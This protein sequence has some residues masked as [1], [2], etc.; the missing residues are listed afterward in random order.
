MGSFNERRQHARIGVQWKLTYCND[1]LFGQGTL[2][3]ISSVG[4]HVAGTMPVVEGMLLNVR[5]SPL[6]R[7]EDLYV[8]EAKVLW[9]RAQEF[10]LEIRHVLASDQR[11]LQGFLENAERRHSFRQGLPVIK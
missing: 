2:L 1:E 3:N 7:D 6:H 11:W 10:G 5:I 9:V 8:S 4:C